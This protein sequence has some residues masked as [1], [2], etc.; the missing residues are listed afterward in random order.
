MSTKRAKSF[1][2]N[3]ADE[4]RYAPS[5]DLVT[6]ATKKEAERSPTFIAVR[7]I[8]SGL[9]L[10]DWHVFVVKYDGTFGGWNPL[11]EELPELWRRHRHAMRLETQMLI[12]WHIVEKGRRSCLDEM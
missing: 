6:Y 8:E 9:C 2:S 4:F 12:P 5:V 11:E 3:G 10:D 7:V 1:L